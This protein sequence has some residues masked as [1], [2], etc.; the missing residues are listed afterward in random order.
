MGLYLA[1]IAKIHIIDA[2]LERRKEDRAMRS[3]RNVT[4][5]GSVQGVGFRWTSKRLAEGLGLDGWVRNNPDGSVSIA[6]EGE[7]ESIDR[8]LDELSDKMGFAIHEVKS[9][10]TKPGKNRDGFDVVH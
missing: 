3:A 10:E 4:I 5:T 6:V 8:F 2:P 9:V 7:D 1:G